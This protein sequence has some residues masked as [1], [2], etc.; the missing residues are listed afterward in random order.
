MG[1]LSEYPRKGSQWYWNWICKP[2]SESMLSKADILPYTG[3]IIVGL[4]DT[5][6]ISHKHGLVSY[7]CGEREEKALPI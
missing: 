7:S 4:V 6:E 1:W 5:Y 2:F 3:A